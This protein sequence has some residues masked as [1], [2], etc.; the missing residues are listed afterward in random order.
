MSLKALSVVQGS[1]SL[2]CQSIVFSDVKCDIYSPLLL[3]EGLGVRSRRSNVI[4][5]TLAFV[6]TLV[7]R[8]H[9]IP[10]LSRHSRDPVK[11]GQGE[12]T[13]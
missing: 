6:F 1:L 11:A 7:E 10:L 9:L 8:P 4:C 2:L 5:N 3:G 12:E 13:F